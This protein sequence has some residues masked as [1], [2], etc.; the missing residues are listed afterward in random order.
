MAFGYAWGNPSSSHAILI[1]GAPWSVTANL[2][3]AL[4]ALR[5][6]Y[7]IRKQRLLVWADAVC[8]N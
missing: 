7:E 8:I 4:T 6:S 2:Y 1:N 5:D 3:Q